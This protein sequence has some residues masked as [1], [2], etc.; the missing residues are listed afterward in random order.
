[1]PA[2]LDLNLLKTLHALIEEQ[3]VTRAAARLSL[4]QPTVSG[5]LARLRHHFDDPLLVRTPQGMVPTERARALAAPLARILGDIDALVQPAAFDPAALDTVFKIGITDNAFATIALP[6]LQKIQTLAPNVKTAFFS[7]QHEQMEERLAQGALD[8]AIAARVAAPE[9][10]RHKVLYREH[11]VCAMRE[12]HPVLSQTWN[13]DTFCAQDFVLGSFF[14]GG[15]SG[16]V[17][18][19]LAQTGHARRVAVSV[20]G[21]AQIPAILRQS[22]LFAVVPSRLVRHETDLAVR[23]LPF[24]VGSYDKLLVWHERSHADPAQQWLRDRLGETE[25]AV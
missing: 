16:A 24:A 11:F 17:D 22:D 20:Q 21:F 5:M 6:F 12:N 2:N 10:L 8:A 23:D 4:T 19:A 14:G 15:F 18:K 1:M 7:L 25:E 9:R 13:A 3:S